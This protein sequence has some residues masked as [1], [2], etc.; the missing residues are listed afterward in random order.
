MIGWSERGTRPEFKLVT[1]ISTG[2]LTAPFAFLGADYD[3]PLKEVY[4]TISETD[5]LVRRSM[6]AAVSND[7]M[8]DN[9]PLWEVVSRYANEDMLQAI[10]AEHGQN[11]EP[12]GRAEPTL[13]Q[14]PAS[15]RRPLADA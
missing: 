5:V 11:V 7:A 6:I 12:R 15:E 4:T 3:A 9:R 13:A 10:A 14:R 1:G 2:A 8:A